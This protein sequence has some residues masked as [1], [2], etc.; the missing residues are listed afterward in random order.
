M[1]HHPF[2]QGVRILTNM[3]ISPPIRHI[4]PNSRTPPL[5]RRITRTKHTLSKIIKAMRNM[6]LHLLVPLPFPHAK[7]IITMRFH[8]HIEAMELVKVGYAVAVSL[9]GGE[10][11]GTGEGGV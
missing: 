4:Q 8:N 10:V 1:I 11:P 3:S 5:Q 7:P 2:P 6:P 9:D